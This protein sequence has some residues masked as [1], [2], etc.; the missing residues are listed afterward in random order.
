MAKLFRLMVNEHDV[1]V[2]GV[3]RMLRGS[4]SSATTCP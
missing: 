2:S 3:R 4:T 1:E